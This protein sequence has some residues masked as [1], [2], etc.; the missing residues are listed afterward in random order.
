MLPV[1][2]GE[3]ETAKQIL[4]YALALL[5]L[6]IAPFAAGSF[7]LVYL[8][9]ALALGFPFVALAA[10]LRRRTTARNAAA[11]FHYSILYLALLFTAAAL[12]R[13]IP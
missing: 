12:D 10:R 2:R 6:S 11:L 7:G 13:A 8:V 9:A 1:V 4:L 5:A 3:R